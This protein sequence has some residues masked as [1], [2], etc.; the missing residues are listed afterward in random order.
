MTVHIHSDINLGLERSI[1]RLIYTLKPPLPFLVLIAAVNHTTIILI[2]RTLN[3]SDA[4]SKILRSCTRPPVQTRDPTAMDKINE[5]QHAQG[6]SNVTSAQPVVI[7]AS[8]AAGLTDIQRIKALISRAQQ[9][10]EDVSIHSNN[11]GMDEEFANLLDLAKQACNSVERSR[12][13]AAKLLGE[14]IQRF[15]AKQQ[16]L[17][18]KYEAEKVKAKA[19][20]RETAESMMEGS[21]NGNAHSQAAAEEKIQELEKENIKQQE[22]MDWMRARIIVL[23][24]KL[25]RLRE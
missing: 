10:Y 17:V 25:R 21:T 20:K 19:K 7:A 13:N 11:K 15:L 8:S 22:E 14:S 5:A 2:R 4:T 24:R 18:R 16:I 6:D 9:Q 23:E 12:T 3:I 1:A